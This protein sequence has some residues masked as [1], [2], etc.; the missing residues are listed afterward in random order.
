MDALEM[1]SDATVFFAPAGLRTVPQ[2]GSGS[3]IGP[4]LVRSATAMTARCAA[5]LRVPCTVF[6][7][8]CREFGRWT[9]GQP[10]C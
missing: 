4:W 10:R 9:C 2:R 8:W 5:A 6:R 1:P 3:R 7:C